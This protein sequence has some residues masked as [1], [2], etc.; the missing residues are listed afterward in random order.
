MIWDDERIKKHN[1]EHPEDP[2]EKLGDKAG[3]YWG[4]VKGFLGQ[5]F[6]GASDERQADVRDQL[7]QRLGYFPRCGGRSY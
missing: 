6:G 1:K 5:H 4:G 3:R 2:Y 7:S